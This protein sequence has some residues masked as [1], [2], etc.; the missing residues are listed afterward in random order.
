MQTDNTTPMMAKEY[1]MEIEKTIPFYS[2]YY[3]QTVDLVQSLPIKEGKWLD[4]GCGTGQFISI[5]RRYFDNFE[6][7]LCDPSEAMVDESKKKLNGAGNIKDIVRC[8]SHEL[9]YI[10]EFDIIT[11]IQCHHYMQYE[12]RLK[13]IQN[14]RDALKGK[15]VFIFFE[16][17][18]PNCEYAKRTVLDR[19][20][21]YQKDRGKSDKEVADHIGRYGKNYFPITLDEHYKLLRDTG[22]RHM[23]IFWLSYMQVGM[24]AVK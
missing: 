6:F 4:A 10:N 12:D 16:N 20:G 14:C 9:N 5:A 23:E 1:D 15:G 3:R 24:Y 7:V 2:E 13:A 21:R 19:W 8:G 22:F 18:A 17:F 11:A